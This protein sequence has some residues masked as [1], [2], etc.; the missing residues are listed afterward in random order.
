MGCHFLLQGNLP[1]PGIES[2][3]LALAGGFF[4]SESRGKPR[5]LT[6]EPIL[7]YPVIFLPPFAMH[8]TIPLL[9]R[10]LCFI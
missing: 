9:H 10:Q 2:M 6:E 1:N 5:N 4:T 7:S 3:S 8:F